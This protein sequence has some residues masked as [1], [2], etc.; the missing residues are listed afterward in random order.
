M[1]AALLGDNIGASLTPSLHEAEGAALGLS[2]S[3]GRIDTA[4]KTLSA[5]DLQGVLKLA[6]VDGYSGLNIT[7]PH[8]TVAASAVDQLEGVA[9][10]LGSVN[11]ILFKN[12]KCLGYNTDYG[13]FQSAFDQ[14]FGVKQ[15]ETVL[16]CGAGGAGSA[17]ALA[18][19]DL[20]F[21]RL[22]LV[23]PDLN[24]A[25]EL[26]SRLEALRP[27]I[28]VSASAGVRDVPFEYLSGAVNCSPL[29]MTGRPGL[30]FDPSLLSRKAWVVDI[31]YFPQKT[32]FLKIAEAHGCQT[33]GGADMALWQAVEAFELLTGAKPDPRRMKHTMD[34]LLQ[35]GS[36][37]EQGRSA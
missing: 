15:N 25:V 37:A 26:K 2:Y 28:F 18:L 7:H 14:R 6:E 34:W 36:E 27:S 32:A 1:K 9:E 31:V 5:A 4:G 10:D 8:K 23:D 21:D 12:G 3:Y 11:T 20:G 29:G 19:A 30:A 16:L 24:K 33:M 22:V 13:G 17:V 35:N